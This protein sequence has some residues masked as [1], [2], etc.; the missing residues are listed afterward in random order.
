MKAIHPRALGFAE[1]MALRKKAI[2]SHLAAF[3]RGAKPRIEVS[4][5]AALAIVV[6]L[7]VVVGVAMFLAGVR[8]SYGRVVDANE[9]AARVEQQLLECMNGSATWTYPN[10]T[11][12]GY[13]KTAVRCRGAEEFAI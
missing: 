8:L 10:A 7:G 11:G 9:R 2:D 12:R 3:H 5:Y 13:S 6:G 1:S 4:L